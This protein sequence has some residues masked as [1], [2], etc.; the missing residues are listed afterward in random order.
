MLCVLDGLDSLCGGGT[1]SCLS[2]YIYIHLS[3]NLI[4]QSLG[5]GSC[6]ICNR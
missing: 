4:Q 6:I 5:C 2:L 1:T 3:L